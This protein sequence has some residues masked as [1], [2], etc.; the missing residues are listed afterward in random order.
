VNSATKNV[1]VAYQRTQLVRQ[2]SRSMISLRHPL[3]ISSP[4]LVLSCLILATPL[5]QMECRVLSDQYRLSETTTKPVTHC[6]EIVV[7]LNQLRLLF[8]V[9]FFIICIVL[10]C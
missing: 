4:K 1:F 7:G 8:A 9:Y 10:L 3:N 5:Q 6:S 2:L